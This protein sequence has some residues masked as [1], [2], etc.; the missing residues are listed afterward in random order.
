MAAAQCIPGCGSLPRAHGC[1]MKIKPFPIIPPSPSSPQSPPEQPPKTTGGMMGRASSSQEGGGPTTL[2]SPVNQLLRAES[3]PGWGGDSHQFLSQP[4]LQSSAE[5]ARGSHTALAPALGTRAGQRRG[6]QPLALAQHCCS[7]TARLQLSNEPRQGR[8]QGSASPVTQ[9]PW[10]PSFSLHSSHPAPN[11][12]SPAST[13]LFLLLLLPSKNH[14]SPSQSPRHP[15]KE[16]CAQADD[17]IPRLISPHWPRASRAAASAAWGGCST[18][19]CMEHPPLAAP[20]ENPAL[21]SPFSH[22]F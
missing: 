14:P 5:P 19:P 4:R 8:S 6:Q 10:A 15:Y 11:P 17:L 9:H 13:A 22:H 3:A 12:G 7:G 1:L 2:L 18:Q 21:F 16:H 20:A